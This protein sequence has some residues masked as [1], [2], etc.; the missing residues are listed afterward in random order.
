MKAGAAV[1]HVSNAQIQGGVSSVGE[2]AYSIQLKSQAQYGHGFESQVWQGLDFS[3]SI[4]HLCA[5][6]CIDICVHI[7]NPKHWQLYIVWTDKNTAHTDSS[8]YS[9]VVVIVKSTGR[10]STLQS[11]GVASIPPSLRQ[12]S[13]GWFVNGV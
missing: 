8:R 7:K 3:H 12:V 1:R 10:G 13:V 11:P 4:Q 9:A 5:I 6:V 2:L